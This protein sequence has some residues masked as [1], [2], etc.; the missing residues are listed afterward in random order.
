MDKSLKRKFIILAIITAAIVVTILLVV[1]IYHYRQ[2]DKHLELE[3]KQ[4]RRNI[5]L[6][7]Q[8]EVYETFAKQM[9]TICQSIDCKMEPW[10][11]NGFFPQGIRELAF[12][13][14]YFDPNGANLQSRGFL[15]YYYHLEL[16][17][18]FTKEDQNTWHLNMS[19][20]GM[21]LK[22][23]YTLKLDK[24]VKYTKQQLAD[25]AKEEYDKLINTGM[26]PEYNHARKI[27]FMVKLSLLNEA[28]D[29]CC[30]AIEDFPNNWWF[31]LTL[32]FIDTGLG[33]ND[34][35]YNSLAQ[36]TNA[37]PRFTHYFYL[38]YF[39]YKENRKSEVRKALLHAIKCPIIVE[40][41]SNIYTDAFTAIICA[42][43]I[44]D[45]DLAIKI[46]DV[47]IDP[48]REK[49]RTQFFGR[50]NINFASLRRKI[51]SR[52]ADPTQLLFLKY[53]VRPFNP[54]GKYILYKTYVV[55]G[56][57]RFESSRD[58]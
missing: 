33:N 56:N 23:L 2:F 17:D 11:F 31:R 30:L 36:W 26:Q 6:M 24:S 45:Y 52:Q 47:M 1:L 15:S 53:K 46:C 19:A 51:K 55:V 28:Y 12:N 38:A 16:N 21:G 50:N 25:K 29:A 18:E 4:A 44:K 3:A 8:P 37:N 40:D 35:A 48:D 41:G 20:D 27:I 57:H 58:F 14:G 49:E 34:R 5:T 13:R 43:D 10:D 32:A 42:L 9:A 39:S 7:Q 22:K 54:Y